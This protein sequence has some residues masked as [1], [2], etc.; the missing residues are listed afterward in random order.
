MHKGTKI[1]FSI[2]LKFKYYKVELKL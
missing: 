1:E 2:L